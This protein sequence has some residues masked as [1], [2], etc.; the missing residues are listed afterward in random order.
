MSDNEWPL[1]EADITEDVC[2]GCAIC[3]EIEIKPNWEDPRQLEWLHAIVENHDNIQNS[4][5]G[6]KI[7][8]SHLIDNY[9]CGIYERR[10][11]M[12]RDFNCV[13]WAK[14]SNNL[15]QYNKVLDKL[16]YN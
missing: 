16:G 11:K 7:R 12:C 6:I 4:E 10:P 5:R 8:C 15:T 2:K 9:K 1:Q 3:C 14:V 13:S